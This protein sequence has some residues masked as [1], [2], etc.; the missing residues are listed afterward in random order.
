M[1]LDEKN[2]ENILNFVNS[3]KITRKD[4]LPTI[5]RS[6]SLNSKKQTHAKIEE[7]S[8]R[9]EERPPLPKKPMRA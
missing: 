7:K 9:C 6:S 8:I 3:S 2:K 1:N 4:Q 5:N